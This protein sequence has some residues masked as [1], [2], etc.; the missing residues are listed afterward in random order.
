MNLLNILSPK[1]KNVHYLLRYLKFISWCSSSENERIEVHHICPKAKDMFPEY[2]SLRDHEWNKKLLTP[3]QH[4]IAHWMLWKAFGGSQTRAFWKMSHD[5]TLHSKTCSLL[6]D[7]FAK[8]QSSLMKGKKKSPAHAQK[9]RENLLLKTNT[10]EQRQRCK[11]RLI[12]HEVTPEMRKKIAIG[13]SSHVS[14][15][16]WINDGSINKRILRSEDIPDGWSRGRLMSS[17]LKKKLLESR[18]FSTSASS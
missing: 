15:T 10:P 18:G 1:S 4:F 9:L 3:R 12:G 14:Q 16:I 11:E 2:R 17:D 5:K 13:V 7:D 8:S 6:K